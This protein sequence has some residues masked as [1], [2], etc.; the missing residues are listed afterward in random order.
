MMADVR[1]CVTVRCDECVWC[2]VQC[3]VLQDLSQ[4]AN[5]VCH[6][7]K[8]MRGMV[9]MY[10]GISYTGFCKMVVSNLI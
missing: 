7:H 9:C 5:V 1:M 4:T 3:H 2:T 8:V 6:S 10:V